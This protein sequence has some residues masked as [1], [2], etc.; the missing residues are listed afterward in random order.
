MRD[1]VSVR[2]FFERLRTQ[3]PEIAATARH[4]PQLLHGI[5]QQAV[6]GKLR[7]QVATA[8]VD[9]LRETVRESQKKRDHTF[10]AGIVLLGGLI[11]LAV[12]RAPLWPGALLTVLGAIWI[13]IA[14]RR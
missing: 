11:W 1:Q 10:V 4:L 3:L 2:A 12:G 6:D 8:G 9:Q 13:A 5:V 7:V 14:W